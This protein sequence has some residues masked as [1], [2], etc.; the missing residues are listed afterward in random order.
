MRRGRRPGRSGTATR[1]VGAAHTH[2]KGEHWVDVEVTLPQFVEAV[3]TEGASPREEG[4]DLRRLRAQDDSPHPARLSISCVGTGSA[5]SSPRGV[6][7]A[8]AENSRLDTVGGRLAGFVFPQ[9]NDVPAGV[10]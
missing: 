10:L 2:A 7:D 5:Q 6:G 8:R 3:L 9:A 1:S 4:G